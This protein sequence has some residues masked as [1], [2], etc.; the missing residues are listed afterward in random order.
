MKSHEDNNKFSDRNDSFEN[1]N[2]EDD[3]HDVENM[4]NEDENEE[5]DNNSK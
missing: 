2:Q 4:V 1:F 5:I 3:D